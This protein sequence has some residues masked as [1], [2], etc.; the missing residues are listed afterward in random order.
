MILNRPAQTNRTKPDIGEHVCNIQFKQRDRRPVESCRTEVPKSRK[1]S[2]ACT[3]LFI[4]FY[5]TD[6]PFR[7]GN[8]HFQFGRLTEIHNG[9]DYRCKYRLLRAAAGPGFRADVHQPAYKANGYHCQHRYNHL[10]RPDRHSEAFKQ[11]CK[12]Q[13]VPYF[14]QLSLVFHRD[15]PHYSQSKTTKARQIIHL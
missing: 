11:P 5:G 4:L 13:R 15:A 12:R 9:H 6:S 1:H 3:L 10:C 2:S 8:V 14:K 7:L